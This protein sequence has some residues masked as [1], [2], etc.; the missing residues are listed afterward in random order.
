[1]LRLGDETC[2]SQ[3]GAGHARYNLQRD[4]WQTVRGGIGNVQEW[5]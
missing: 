1:M 4:F 3:T 2:R 5:L